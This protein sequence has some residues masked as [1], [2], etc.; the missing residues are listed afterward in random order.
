MVTEF[1][2]DF[3][4]VYSIAIQQTKLWSLLQKSK[5]SH[6]RHSRVGGNP[7]IIR[8]CKKLDPKFSRG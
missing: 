5:K 1:V 3:Q 4:S 2:L 6:L 8:D 7:E